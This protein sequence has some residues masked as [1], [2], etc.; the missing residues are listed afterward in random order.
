MCILV[1]DPWD[2]DLLP[3][4]LWESGII[5]GAKLARS[6]VIGSPPYPPRTSAPTDLADKPFDGRRPA[7]FSFHLELK[8][9]YILFKTRSTKYVCF[10]FK[11]A[12]FKFCY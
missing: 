4:W 9:Y 3:S 10:D 1:E 6:T 2:T 12:T 11:I 5:T 8:Q 7:I